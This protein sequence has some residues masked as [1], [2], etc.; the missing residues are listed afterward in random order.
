VS[1]NTN[2]TLASEDWQ[3]ADDGHARPVSLVVQLRSRAWVLPYFRWV[4]ASGDNDQVKITFASHV[5]T[6]TGNGLSVLLSAVAG[7][8]VMQLVQPTENELKFGVRGINADQVT[9][10]S[11]TAITVEQFK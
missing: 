5:V 11:I 4:C 10:P 1:N 3:L 2:T 6:V 8:R 7:Q 9:G